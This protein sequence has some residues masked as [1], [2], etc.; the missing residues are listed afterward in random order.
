[1]SK[2]SLCRWFSRGPDCADMSAVSAC[3]APVR[4]RP[5]DMARR[6]RPC[7]GSGPGHGCSGQGGGE[8]HNVIVRAEEVIATHV[9]TDF[10]AFGSLLA[11]RCLYPGSTAALPSVLDRNVREFVRLHADELAWCLRHGARQEVLATFLRTPLSEEERALMSAL[12]ETADTHRES[13]TE[14]LVAA[15]SWP[16]YV[17]GISHLAHKITDVTDCQ[18]LALL[19][20]MDRRVFGV[21]RSRTADFDAGAAAAS[22]GGGGHPQAASAIF[23]GSLKKARKLF[24]DR[25][26]EAVRKPLRARDVMAK[27]ARSVTPDETVAAAMV[28]CQ[29]YGQSGILV[30]EGDRLVGSVR[31]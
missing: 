16:R 17:E 1:M 6:F 9:N 27:P 21:V 29:R 13:G 23:R 11:A 30:T 15:V 3:D 4:T 22:L 10:D 7:P 12:L 26:G 20:E 28:V 14:I 8:S 19:V 25:L 31:R 5:G 24:L 2:I 18:A